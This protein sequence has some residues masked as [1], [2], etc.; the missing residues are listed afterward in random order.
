METT[1]ERVGHWLGY[2]PEAMPRLHAIDGRIDGFVLPDDLHALLARLDVPP[3]VA[4]E[5]VAA[6]PGPETH[7]EAWWLLEHLYAQVIER[8][9]PVVEPPWPAPFPDDDPLTHFFH[10]YVFLA[11]VPDVLRL[12]GDRGIPADVSW[13]TLRDV[14]LQVDNYRQRHGRYGFDG[15][16]WIWQHF[17]GVIYRLGRLEFNFFEVVFDPGSSAAFARGDP[18]L[19]VH[20]PAYGPLDPDACD[21]SFGLAKAFFRRHFPEHPFA[22]ATCGSWLL[23][24][25]LA[26]YL[27]ESANIIRFQRRF[28]AVPDWS[29]VADDDVLRFVFGSVPG[30]LD[31]LPQET[32]LQRAI[33]THLRAGQHWEVRQGWIPW[34]AD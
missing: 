22:V 26:S 31:E 27:P 1:V 15:A 32:T 13:A 8:E 29:R 7:P 11:A 17:R 25:Q 18:A 5:I 34:D 2:A 30:S 3:P 9:R 16:F 10:L 21:A 28:T 19:G 23:D 33:V 14:W 20:I 4:D 12:H 24:P 6:A